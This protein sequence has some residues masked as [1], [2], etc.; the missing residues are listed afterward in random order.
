MYHEVTKSLELFRKAETLIAGQTQLLSRHPSLHAFGVS[1]I[2]A[3]RASGCRFWDVDGNEYIDMSGGTGVVYLGY[4]QPEVDAAAI[5]QI[6]KGVAYAVNSP[7]EIELA[8]LLKEA[9]PCAQM[10]RYAKGGGDADAV[11]VRIARAHTGRDKV[12][13]CGYHGW[14]DWYIAANLAK[15]DTLNGHLLPGVPSAGV[16]TSL[17][18]T[19]LPFAYN[20]L[21]DLERKLEE[22]RGQIA[23]I[24]MEAARHQQ[25]K[26]GFLEKVREL[27]SAH[28]A[29]LIFDEVVTGFR[30]SR[31]GA[32]EHFAVTPDMA[33]FGKAIGNGYPIAAI[34]G[35][36]EVMQAVST[37]FISS[38]YWS[39]PASMAAA[40][41][42]QKIIRNGDVIRHIWR[43]GERYQEGLLK[44]G[45]DLGLPLFVEGLPPVFRFGLKLERP[46]PYMTLVTQEMAK[47]GVHMTGGVYIM[48]A[49]QPAD[50]DTVLVALREVSVT[51]H[52]A[53]ERGS[54]E[55]LLEVPE[56]RPVFKRRQV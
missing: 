3:D 27:A 16:P 29:V 30:Y 49:H 33:T 15:A 7:L 2:Y 55:G 31:G 24:I 37:S 34:A 18:G 47:R 26:P 22:N 25:P 12:L 53:V 46:G 4:C 41:A 48:A 51:L 39:E 40:I 28:G 20:D 32:Q 54:V 19:A 5:A 43:M 52:K 45:K 44:L 42:I 6:K 38:S 8:E 36:K 11:A 13:F 50:I 14:H 21:P 35:R 1:P 9:I 23:C 56:A 17:A 10:V